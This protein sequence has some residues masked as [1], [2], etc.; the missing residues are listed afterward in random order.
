M[1]N[2]FGIT[3]K[4]EN[5]IAHLIFDYPAEKFNKLSTPV[6]QSLDRVADWLQQNAPTI[7][8][9]VISSAK[10]GIFIVGAD[11]DEIKNITDAKVGEAAAS[12]GQAIFTKIERLPFP[13]VC[14]INGACMGGGTELALACHYRLAT[15]HPKTRIGLP[16]V[17]LGIVPG[18]GGTQRMPRLIGLQR[19]LQLIL[20]GKALDA[21]RAYKNALVD[22][23]VPASFPEKY[24]EEFVNEI[25]SGKKQKY[26]ERRKVKGLVNRLLEGPGKGLIYSQARKSVLKQTKGHYPAPLCALQA[27]KEGFS[28]SLSEGL[29]IEARYLG[30]MIVTPISKNLI[31]IYYLTEL[32]KKSNGVSKNS[33][34]AKDFQYTGVLGAGV[35]GGGIAQLFA[36]NDV[37]VRLKDINHQAIGLGLSSARKVFDKQLK[38]KRITKMELDRKMSFISGSLNYEGFKRT[39]L[40]VEAIVENMDIKKKVIAEL[41]AHVNT[42]T[43]IASNT[44]SLS[45]TEMATACKRPENFIG[46]HFFNPVHRMPL[47]EIIRGRHTSDET[48]AAIYQFSKKIGKTPIVVKDGPGFLVNRLLMPYLNEAGF[49]LEEGVSIETLDKTMTDFGMPMGPCLLLD[50]VGID[51]AYKVGHIFQEAFGNR[52]QGSHAVEKLY[53]DKRLGKKGGLGFYKHNN[54]KPIIDPTVYSLIQPKPTTGIS[55]ENM[56]QRMTYAMINEA[57]M[58]LTEGIVEKPEDVDI[59]MIFGTGFPPFFGGLLRY[60]DTEGLDKIVSALDRLSQTF[61]E[62]FKPCDYL[63]QMQQLGKKFYTH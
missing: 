31:R 2:L 62:R 11:I 3:L 42:D 4:I 61:G 41:D 8:A 46:M 44:S 14:L 49:L 27:V 48:V 15:D 1:E 7:K 60:A 26:I 58:C 16:E 12:A 32:I 29:K 55:S 56:I 43:I 59:G 57:A 40:V 9:C 34:K 13:V 39:E 21:G 25:I 18:F 51:V 6:M 50:E 24:A 36:A 35:M 20:T 38:R 30:E 5:E 10:D 37:D 22:K 28:K 23:V 52:V 19:S 47:V 45:I 63:R 33:I 17:M 53:N 54:G